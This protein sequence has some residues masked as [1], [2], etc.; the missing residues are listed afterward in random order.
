MHLSLRCRARSK[1]SGKPCRAP[2][3]KGKTVCR[4]HGAGAPAG[5]RSAFGSEAIEARRMIAEL[6]GES[7]ELAEIV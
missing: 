1:P 2:A 7:R 4:M 3:V 6:I 5:N